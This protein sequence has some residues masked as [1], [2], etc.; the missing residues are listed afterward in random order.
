[1]R[2]VGWTVAAGLVLVAPAAAGQDLAQRITGNGDGEVR[3]SFATR[4]DVCGDGQ[5]NIRS[6]SRHRTVDQDVEVE[7]ATDC[8]CEYGPARVVLTV[9]DHRVTRVRTWVGGRWR[10]ASDRTTDLGTV[11]APAAALALLDLAADARN[12]GGDDAIFPATLADSVTIWPRLLGVARDTRAPRD[13]RRQAVFW[14][15]QAAGD[16]ATVGL[17]Q[18]AENENEDG[19]VRK[20]AVFAL[21]QRPSEEGVPALIRIARSNRDPELRRTALFWLGQ[22]DDPR[23]LALFEELLVRK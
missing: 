22:S 1:M 15:S 13:S 21:S 9:R 23:A 19:D 14:V 18:L 8:P 12:S 4:P 2:I 10:E 16:S 11:P 5:R 20:Q 7:G 3:L 17:Q 6:G